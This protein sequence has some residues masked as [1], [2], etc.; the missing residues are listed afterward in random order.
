MLK[1]KEMISTTQKKMPW[2]IQMLDAVCVHSQRSACT[3][4][5]TR[6]CSS[7]S[8]AFRLVSFARAYMSAS[9][10]ALYDTKQNGVSAQKNRP[11]HDA[12]PHMIRTLA[13]SAAVSLSFRVRGAALIAAAQGG[14]A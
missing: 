13:T 11:D 2:T 14:E 10:C 12:T 3:Q 8:Q 7:P 1:T 6:T 4:S 9:P 5:G